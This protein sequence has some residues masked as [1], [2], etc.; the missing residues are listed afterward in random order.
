MFFNKVI[1]HIYYLDVLNLH[2]SS[3]SPSP[4]C[5]SL[6]LGSGEVT[7][8]FVN[9]SPVLRVCALSPFSI[10]ISLREEHSPFCIIYVDL[11]R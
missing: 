2:T 1:F 6:P 8:V 7:Q 3:P 4:P 5:P 9:A 10:V 11:R